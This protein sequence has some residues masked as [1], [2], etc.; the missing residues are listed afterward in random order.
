M[1][2]FITCT[3]GLARTA[4]GGNI[5]VGIDRQIDAPNVMALWNVVGVLTKIFTIKKIDL[6]YKSMDESAAAAGEQII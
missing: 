5:D 3:V 1:F 6:P 4:D 2:R